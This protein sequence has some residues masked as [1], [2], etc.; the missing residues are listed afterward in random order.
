MITWR[1]RGWNEER[2][3]QEGARQKEARERGRRGRREK[4][5]PFILGQAYLAVAR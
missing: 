4:A 1:G 5:A 2:G 3:E